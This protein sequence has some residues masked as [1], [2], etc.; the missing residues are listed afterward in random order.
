M[1]APPTLNL[2]PSTKWQI[3]YGEWECTLRRGFTDEKGNAF[4]FSLPRK[5]LT[6]MAYLRLTTKAL[7]KRRDDG[8][9][10]VT[11]DGVPQPARSTYSVFDDDGGIRVRQFTLPRAGE[12]VSA[13]REQL[14]FT[15]KREGN[16]AL[17][18]DGLAAA[19][20]ALSSCMD[21]LNA[22]LGTGPAALSAMATEPVGDWSDVV[23]WPDYSS[24]FKFV[25]LYWVGA[26][27]RV[28]ECRLLKP[29]ADKG[30]ND[31]FCQDLR[32]KA[33][34]KPA[35]DRAGKPIRVPQFHDVILRRQIVR[36]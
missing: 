16:I 28:D 34:F 4:V 17:K 25:T 35:K 8:D 5:P 18:I 22:A 15:T 12:E 20:K 9:A 10:K 19:T 7:P 21:D 2:A 6:E 36:G 29:S 31:R 24:S 27:G 1:A 32:A 30:F 26:D 14:I 13:T 11:I 33:K 3:D 23:K